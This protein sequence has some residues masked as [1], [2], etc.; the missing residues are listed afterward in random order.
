MDSS[1]NLP[2]REQA[3]FHAIAAQLERSQKIINAEL[4]LVRSMLRIGMQQ[5]P[6]DR[7]PFLDWYRDLFLARDEKIDPVET[8]VIALE[9]I[10]NE[11]TH[12]GCSTK[13]ILHWMLVDGIPDPDHPETNLT[14]LYLWN[15]YGFP[16]SYRLRELEPD[17]TRPPEQFQ[18]HLPEYLN[19]HGARY[20][21]K[22]W[23]PPQVRQIRSLGHHYQIDPRD[24]P[25]TR[26]HNE[27]L[28]SWYLDLQAIYDTI[29][30]DYL[31]RVS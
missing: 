2:T 7:R 29:Y 31:A 14:I 19:L 10:G 4:A 23:L 27:L 9:T 20:R 5:H 17:A 16:F 26:D 24:L 13:Q 22:C 11:A 25:C 21:L 30:Q 12:K 3:S 6:L 1:S 18:K 28:R 15:E 8:I